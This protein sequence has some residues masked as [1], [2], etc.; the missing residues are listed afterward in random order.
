MLSTPRDV[1]R[2]SARERR[3]AR[4]KFRFGDARTASS[5]PAAPFFALLPEEVRLVPGLADLDL[6]ADDRLDALQHGVRRAVVVGTRLPLRVRRVPRLDDVLVRL[7]LDAHAD[8]ED[9]LLE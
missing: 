8:R 9:V 1:E 4:N 3:R 5:A 7:A 2:S 6:V